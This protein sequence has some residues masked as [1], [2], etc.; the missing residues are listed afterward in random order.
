MRNL[1]RLAGLTVA[2]LAWTALSLTPAFAAPA[3][4]EAAVLDELNFARTQ[5]DAY[6]RELRDYRDLFEGRVVHEDRDPVGVM[7]NEGV[8]A[9]DEAIA[10]LKRQAPLEPLDASRMLD[11]AALGHVRDQGRRGAVGHA[12]SD[13]S[14]LGQRIQR[15][16][17]WS[18]G[19]AEVISYGKDSPA[20]VVRQLIIDDGVASRGHRRNIFNPGF[21]YAGVGCGEHRVH[22]AMCVIDF[23]NGISAR[24]GASP[25]SGSPS[26]A[27]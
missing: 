23:A 2:A 20:A 8:A 27:R 10:F 17:L 7:T 26:R 22:G 11:Q 1:E 18:G 13:G 14:S 25:P 19:V 4:F 3:S 9:V 21:R 6:A 24:Q 16:G 5:P 15:Q 12:G